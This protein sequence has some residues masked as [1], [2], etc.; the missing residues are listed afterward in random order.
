[1]NLSLDAREQLDYRITHAQPLEATVFRSV[2]YQYFHPDDVISGEGTRRY[3][4]R[5]VPIGV[6]AV[7]GS[8]DESTAVQEVRARQLM[9][10]GNS[11]I[12]FLEY[13]RMTYA[14]NI[15]TDKHLDLSGGLP[16]DLDSVITACSQPGDHSASQQVA[17]S[18]ISEG[19]E[20]LMF[21]S[22]TGHGKNL[23]VYLSNAPEGSVTVINRDRLLSELHQRLVG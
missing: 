14:L 17:D 21:R 9:L 7:F 20:S 13:P 18:W 8:V 5:F 2:A 15:K 10:K 3:G 23:V 22:A 19:I 4:G 6:S 11:E 12:D 16:S 1:M